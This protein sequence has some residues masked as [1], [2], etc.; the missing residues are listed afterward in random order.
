LSMSYPEKISELAL[1]K[2]RRILGVLVPAIN[3][4][5]FLW[6]SYRLIE[7]LSS[8]NSTG[9]FEFLNLIITTL[10]PLGLGIILPM[11]L[12]VF[13]SNYWWTEDGI[14]IKRLLKGS[15]TIPYNEIARAE[16]YIRKDETV[17]EDAEEYAKQEAEKLRK[18][19]F[20]FK[21]YTNSE[22]IITMLLSGKQ[23]YLISPR[24]PIRLLKKLKKRSPK[25]SAKIVELRSR[26]KYIRDLH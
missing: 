13:E 2:K 4:P 3:L 15:I 10:I 25:L 22:E 9:S 6:G 7:Y 19:G 21:D 17:S 18:A 26:G 12:P 1:D 11:R 8:G 5:M 23:V 14:K 24:K 20:D 16:V